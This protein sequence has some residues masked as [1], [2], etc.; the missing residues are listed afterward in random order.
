MRRI[1]TQKF[2]PLNNVPTTNRI[3]D[4]NRVI[5]FAAQ[6]YCSTNLRAYLL[7]ERFFRQPLAT[8]THP[9]SKEEISVPAGCEALKTPDSG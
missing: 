4:L 2:S 7:D 6:L 3:S 5:L 9:A 8:W 1:V